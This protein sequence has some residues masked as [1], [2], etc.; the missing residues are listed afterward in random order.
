MQAAARTNVTI[1]KAVLEAGANV[2]LESGHYGNALSAAVY[3]GKT[4]IVE[5][6]LDQGAVANTASV[7]TAILEGHQDTV[8]LLEGRLKS[9]A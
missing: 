8:T 7:Q 5:L 1:T 9:Q 4:D 6:L 2:N 3:F